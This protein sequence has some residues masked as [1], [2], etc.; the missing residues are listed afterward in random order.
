[1]NQE[2]KN[3]MNNISLIVNSVDILNT[4]D[5]GKTRENIST[6][7]LDPQ[8]AINILVRYLL[9]EDWKMSEFIYGEEKNSII[10]DAILKKYSRKYRKE[11]REEENLT[12]YANKLFSKID[13]KKSKIHKRRK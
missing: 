2:N 9:G 11:I 12:N 6:D 1:M 3:S 13:K 7:G 5:M 4:K 8:T 10:L